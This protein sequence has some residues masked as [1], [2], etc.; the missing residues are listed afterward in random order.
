VDDDQ[1]I[2]LSSRHGKSVRFKSDQVRAM[3][4]GTRGVK[5]MN[6]ASGDKLVNM[7]IISPQTEA[8]LLTVTENGF[9]KRTNISEYPVQKRGGQGV[10]TIKTTERNGYVVESYQVTDED[11]LMII[12]NGGKVIRLNVGDISVIGRNTQGVKLINISEGEKVSAVCRLMDKEEEGEGDKEE[13]NGPPGTEE[14]E[15]PE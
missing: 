9:G 12:T 6:L 13:E 10:I 7:E 1:E 15:S 2:L 11:D 5:G 4:R 3:G 8:S 14:E